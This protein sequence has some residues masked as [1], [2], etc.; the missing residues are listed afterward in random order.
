VVLYYIS[1]NLIQQELVFKRKRVLNIAHHSYYI[2]ITLPLVHDWIS[3][4]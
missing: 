1:H 4:F 2:I 3:L